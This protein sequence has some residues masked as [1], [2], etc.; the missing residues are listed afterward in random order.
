MRYPTVEELCAVCGRA[1]LEAAYRAVLNRP[2]DLAGLKYYVQ[3]LCD[4]VPKQQVLSE[5]AQSEEAIQIALA[6]AK[7]ADLLTSARR[8]QSWRMRLRGSLRAQTKTVTGLRFQLELFEERLSNAERGL[9]YLGSCESDAA[10][11]LRASDTLAGERDPGARPLPAG[12]SPRLGPAA[13][14]LLSR[15]AS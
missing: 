11:A 7:Q 3:R 12:F 15:L 10:A 5:L 13:V 2:P 1:F 14:R 9:A 4:G 6:D 8:A